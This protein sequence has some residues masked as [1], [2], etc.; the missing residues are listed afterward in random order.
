MAEAA[1]V[2]LLAVGPKA[3]EASEAEDCARPRIFIG[4]PLS[5]GNGDSMLMSDIMLLPCLLKLGGGGV[6]IDL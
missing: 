5:D 2:P 1:G 3:S 6:R 4:Y